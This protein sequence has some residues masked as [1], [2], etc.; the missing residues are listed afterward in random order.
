MASSG[1][2]YGVG[3]RFNGA[4]SDIYIAKFTAGSLTWASTQHSTA[5]GSHDVANGV[6]VD[7]FGRPVI[8]G[9]GNNGTDNDFVVLRYTSAGSLDTSFD[10]DGIVHYSNTADDRAYSLAMDSYGRYLLTGYYYTDAT[11][12]RDAALF[13]IIP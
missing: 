6:I 7:S 13:R 8:T 11:T 2:Y 5:L 12:N 3:M 10:T 4:D 1:V 9:Y